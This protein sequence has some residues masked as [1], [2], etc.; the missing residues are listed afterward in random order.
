MSKK[1]YLYEVKSDVGTKHFYGRNKK[2]VLDCFR[3]ENPGVTVEDVFKVGES[4][5]VLIENVVPF[6]EKEEQQINEYFMHEFGK[7]VTAK[8][9]ADGMTK[10][11]GE[12]YGF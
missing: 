1:T 11:E 10:S 3:K 6:N 9:I 5:V 4:K 8:A 12:K 2:L 7:V